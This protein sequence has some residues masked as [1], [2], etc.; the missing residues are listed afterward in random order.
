M[1]IASTAKSIMKVSS[2]NVPK[3]LARINTHSFTVDHCAAS[4]LFLEQKKCMSYDN[5]HILLLR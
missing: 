2:I 1:N 4:K 5:L 3:S